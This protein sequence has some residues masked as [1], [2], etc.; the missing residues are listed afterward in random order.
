[1]TLLYDTVFQKI[2]HKIWNCIVQ[3]P[4]FKK[5]ICY[6]D[7]YE[8]IFLINVLRNNKVRLWKQMKKSTKMLS[9]VQKLFNFINK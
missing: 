3:R 1:M 2:S 4:F 6:K 7:M 8:S 5:L 9:Y